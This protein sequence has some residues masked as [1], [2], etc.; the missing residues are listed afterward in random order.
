MEHFLV[1]LL[2]SSEVCRLMIVREANKNIQD[3]AVITNMAEKHP[4]PEYDCSFKEWVSAF[5]KIYKSP[6]L[7]AWILY[8]FEKP[9]GYVI[10]TRELLFKDQINVFDIYIEEEFRGKNLIILLISQLR[11]WARLDDVK[12]IQ[13]TSKFDTDKWQRILTGALIGVKVDEYKT[14]SWEVI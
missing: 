9:I 12:R 11:D 1:D 7:R 8:D 13:W 5:S 2:D 10:G 3:L 6:L 4:A 14:L